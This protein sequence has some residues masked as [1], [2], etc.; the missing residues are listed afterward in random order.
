[1]LRYRS[2][3]GMFRAESPA[4]LVA[5]ALSL[6]SQSWAKAWREGYK[7]KAGRF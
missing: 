3:D 2:L 5:A 6:E 4:L 7:K 1:M